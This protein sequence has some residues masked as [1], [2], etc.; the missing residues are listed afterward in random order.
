MLIRPDYA[1]GWIRS[2]L[3]EVL[4][5]LP[6]RPEGVRPTLE[7]VFA[8]HPTS[9]AKAAEA[10]APQKRGAS[11]TMEALKMASQLLSGP[12]SSV[13]AEDWYAGIAPQLFQLLD[14]DDA[15]IR[16]AVAYVIGFGILGNRKF[17]A[18]GTP[19]NSPSLGSW[20]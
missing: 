18:P 9:T 8:V 5:T 7:F 3:M 4:T 6:L 20:E 15:D 13:A 17:G 14:S 11:I 19:L 12:P 2:K 10:G 16:R 1:P